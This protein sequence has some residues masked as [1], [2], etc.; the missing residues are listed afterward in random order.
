M[1][2]VSKDY[3]VE[4]KET[5]ASPKYKVYKGS[6]YIGSVKY[7]EDAAA[8][9]ALQDS[10]TVRLSHKYVLWTQGADGDAGESYDAAAELMRQREREVNE[11]AYAKVYGQQAQ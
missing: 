9:V 11:K 8:L 7:A 4:V 10:G 3:S 5:M 2:P 1:C 6:E